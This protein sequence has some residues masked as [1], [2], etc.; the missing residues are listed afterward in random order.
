MANASLKNETRNIG[1]IRGDSKVLSSVTRLYVSG[2]SA[3]SP[4]NE[5]FATGAGHA[6][7]L[8]GGLKFAKYEAD[9]IVLW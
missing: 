9:S 5:R 3:G 1:G 2:E 6:F 7:Y 4:W 8:D